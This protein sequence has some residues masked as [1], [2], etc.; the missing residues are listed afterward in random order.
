MDTIT[1]STNGTAPITVLTEAEA[2]RIQR[3]EWQ[4]EAARLAAMVT[5][6]EA[7][8][9]EAARYRIQLH[10]L[11]SLVESL[12][13]HD[14]NSGVFS[15]QAGCPDAA[16]FIENAI[17]LGCDESTLRNGM[18]RPFIVHATI[19]LNVTMDVEA[20]SEEHAMEI[21]DGLLHDDWECAD[22]ND[23]D[24]EVIDATE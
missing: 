24:V 9:A 13:W 2:L 20:I 14:I 16:A 11:R 8:R 15:P 3:D 19:T 4:A 17:A 6:E 10:G 23:H 22:V 1:T 12:D 18:E 21:A 5:N 7:L